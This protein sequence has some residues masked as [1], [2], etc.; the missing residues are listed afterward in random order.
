MKVLKLYVKLCVCPSFLQ[1]TGLQSL[2]NLGFSY[3]LGSPKGTSHW[4]R[5]SLKIFLN[6]DILRG[7][8]I[9]L[10]GTLENQGWMPVSKQ[11][12]YLREAP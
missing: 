2:A 10:T 7:S 11:C 6:S 1:T 12:F 8:L 9:P 5:Y 3:V 4:S